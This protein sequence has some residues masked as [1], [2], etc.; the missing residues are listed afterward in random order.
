MG[1]IL[2]LLI[3]RMDT[4][5]GEMLIVA[6]R[7]GNLRAVAWADLE[8]RMSRLLRFHYGENGLKLEAARNPN[9]LTHAISSYFKGD[10]TAIDILPVQTAGTPF[11]REVWRALRNIPCGTTVSYAKLAEQIGRAYGCQGC[12]FG[13]WF[14]SGWNCRALSSRDWSQWFAHRLRWRY[15]AQVLA[16]GA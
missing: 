5:I 15:R 7:E 12:R 4:S 3:N 2:Q 11:Q 16:S 9:S 6:D 1:E 8:T 13:Q 10:L 14:K